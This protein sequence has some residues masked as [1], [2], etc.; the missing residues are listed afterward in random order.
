MAELLKN[1]Y[2]REF[3]TALA[4]Q[5][6]AIFPA[7]D[8]DKFQHLIFDDTWQQKELK[9]RMNHIA[10]CLHQV[11]PGPYHHNLE[12]LK[13]I[14]VEQAGFEYMF[15]PAYVELYG[16]EDYVA[17]IPALA[18]F[19]EFASSEFAVRPF[20]IKYPKQMMAQMALWARM[21][22]KHLRRLASEGCRPRL[23]WAMALPAFKQD[24]AQV[25]PILEV[26]KDDPS[27]YVRRSVANNLN[28]IAKDNPKQVI[29]IAKRWF[30]QTENTDR[31]IKHACRTLLKKADPEIL[32]L[33]GFAPPK[34]IEVTALK[35]QKQVTMGDKL[36][37]SFTLAT[38]AQALGKL[39]IEYAIDYMKS[40]GKQARKI[41]KIAE[42]DYNDR[43]KAITREQ[44][45]KAISTRK[46]YPGAHAVAVIINGEELA[47]DKFILTAA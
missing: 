44:S 17:S 18:H 3:I 34:A 40:N 12:L 35:V 11:L 28:D 36:S 9:A 23:P 27:E 45:F 41:F 46:H 19:T 16:L 26:L 15:L 14:K 39:R 8:K 32:T 37:F 42:A 6:T 4:Q 43:Q 10:Q 25:L 2:T 24:P 20:I 47:A 30:G 38:K 21:D 1:V 13:Q 7:F 33:F 31:L 22:N 29:A 5:L